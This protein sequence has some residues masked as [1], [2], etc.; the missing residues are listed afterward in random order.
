MLLVLL[1]NIYPFKFTVITVTNNNGVYTKFSCNKDQAF[2]FFDQQTRSL[3][4]TKMLPV[5]AVVPC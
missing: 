5:K 4:R 1:N 3:V 2:K